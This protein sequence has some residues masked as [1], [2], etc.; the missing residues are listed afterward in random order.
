M[1]TKR[2]RIFSRIISIALMASVLLTSNGIVVMAENV[3]T[4]E[5]ESSVIEISSAKDLQKIA[6]NLT[7]TQRVLESLGMY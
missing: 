2:K 3:Q 7:S 5:Q 1:L 4:A 6:D